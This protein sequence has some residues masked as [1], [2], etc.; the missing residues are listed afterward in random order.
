VHQQPLA[1]LVL[2]NVGDVLECSR[3]THSGVVRRC[4]RSETV[5]LMTELLDGQTVCL[6]PLAVGV[7]DSPQ[8]LTVSW[9]ELLPVLCRQ[10]VPRRLDLF[11]LLLIRL[12][13]RPSSEL[14]VEGTAVHDSN[15]VRRS[16]WSSWL[17]RSHLNDTVR[18]LTLDG[19]ERT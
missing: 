8:T 6:V 9:T 2:H 13:S 12:L 3:Q 5:A 1:D 18:R 15:G 14:A 10:R 19:N 4:Y 11:S 16:R 17:R 7:V